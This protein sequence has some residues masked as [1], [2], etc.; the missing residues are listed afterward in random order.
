M[1]V[2]FPGEKRTYMAN[3]RTFL[4]WA[5]IIFIL[6]LMG[7]GILK[8]DEGSLA[9]YHNLKNINIAYLCFLSSCWNQFC[10]GDADDFDSRALRLL[11]PLRP[12]TKDMDL[13]G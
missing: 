9:P 11:L 10:W 3:E 2:C 5:R 7:I 13:Q 8:I 6:T 1:Y 4:K 12:D